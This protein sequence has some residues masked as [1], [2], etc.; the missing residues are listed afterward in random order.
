MAEA[1]RLLT[2]NEPTGYAPYSVTAILALILTIVF[3]LTLGVLG[4][5]AFFSGQQLVE[6]LL[7]VL[8]AGVI[9]LAFAA[10]RQIQNSEGTRAGLPFCNFAWWVAVLGGCGYAAYLVGRLIGVQQDTKDA[11]VV[12]M[13]TLEKVNPIDTRTVD[14]HKAF[15]TTLDTG[16]Q[17]SVDVKP[18]EAGKPVD[19]R[20]IEAVQKGFLEDTPG[21]IGV[22]RF[23]QIDLLRILHRNHEFQ[24]KFT[25]DGLQ[26]WQQDASGLRCKSA[27]TLVTPEGS[28]KLN[29][30]M[31]RQIPTG[32]RPV[33]RVVAPTQGFVGGAKFTRYGQQ[34]LEVEAAGRSLVYD[35]LLTV[36]ARAPQVRPMLL[37][38]FNQP[39]F[40]HFDFLKPL[41][42]RAALMGAGASL[43]QEPPGYETQIKSQFFVPLDRLDATRDGDPREKFFAAWREGRIVQPGAILAESPDQAPIMTVTEKSIELRVP[44]EIQLPRTEAS[45]SAARG[46]VVIVCDDAAFLAKLNDLRKSAAVDPL[47][48]PVAPKGDAAV[49]WKLRHIE[50]DMHL[51][52]SSRS[53]DNAPSGQAETPP[54]M[55]K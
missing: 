8:P 30:D 51:V 52:K 6:P 17:E 20:D 45:Q 42:G 18:R 21:M 36:F 15:Q 47:A 23:R 4:I 27:G 53:K 2:T 46:A 3:M 33:W 32:S 48:D 38:E 29:F 37:Q 54:G 49:P 55:P 5:L 31:M 7:L 35:A 10:R 44:V 12:W 22:V 11:L 1:P 50:S 16:R 34:I 39:G 14:F 24:P 13:T 40:Q 28:Y 9:V 43:P 26:S 19:P 25:F 41:S